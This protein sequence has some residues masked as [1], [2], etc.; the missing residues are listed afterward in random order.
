MA[1]YYSMVC[2]HHIFTHSSLSGHLG[3]FH[4]LAIVHSAAVNIRVHVSF[5]IMIFSSYIPRSVIAG[6]YGSPIF[7]LK[8]NLHTVLL[9]GCTNLH[10]HKW[11]KSA[12]FSQ[13]PMCLLSIYMSSLE[14]C[15][16]GSSTHFLIGFFVLLILSC[17]RWLY[18]LEINPLLVVALANICSHSEAYIF[19]LFTVS[20]V[21]QKLLS[22]IRSH[23]F[24]FIF[25]TLGGGLKNIL[26]SLMSECSACFS[27]RVL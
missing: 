20:F 12:P 25:I 2:M 9:S 24:L 27:L 15:L 26:L 14:K 6:A 23:L 11:W 3:F 5:Q 1:E 10:S 22:I 16:F 17:I 21:V 19:T 13:Q 8:G 18:I 4:D 7:S